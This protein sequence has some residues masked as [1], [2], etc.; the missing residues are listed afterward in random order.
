MR[1]TSLQAAASSSRGRRANSSSWVGKTVDLAEMRMFNRLCS[2]PAT[3][4][5]D[6][7]LVRTVQSLCSLT[8]AAFLL[9]I[10]A[11]AVTCICSSVRCYSGF[12]SLNS[13]LQ[14]VYLSLVNLLHL[15]LKKINHLTVLTFWTCVSASPCWGTGR[16]KCSSKSRGPWDRQTLGSYP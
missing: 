12:I 9:Y 2:F 1:G 5:R 3:Q 13:I 10:S 14:L 6:T 8:F 11:I 4:D 16:G 7:F 15:T